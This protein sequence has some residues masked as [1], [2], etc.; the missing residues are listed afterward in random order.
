M[1]KWIILIVLLV[2]CGCVR[3]IDERGQSSWKFDPVATVKG[4][5]A[6]E[7]GFSILNALGSVYPPAA[8]AG[9]LGLLILGLWKKKWKPQIQQAKTESELYTTTTQCFVEA[10]NQIKKDHPKIWK[11]TVLPTIQVQPQWNVKTENAVRG[12]R[13]K[14]PLK[15]M[16]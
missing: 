8:G 15:E 16:A 3:T 10:M 13:G 14:E 11:D 2:V 4:E 12:L 6:A 1:K 5:A 7:A 9:G